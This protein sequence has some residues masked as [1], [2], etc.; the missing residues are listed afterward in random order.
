MRMSAVP[1]LQD[2]EKKPSRKGAGR[3]DFGEESHQ[4]QTERTKGKRL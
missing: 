3:D 4:L 1:R 2:D